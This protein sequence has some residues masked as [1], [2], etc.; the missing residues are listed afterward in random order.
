MDH[1][2]TTTT[3]AAAPTTTSLALVGCGSQKPDPDAFPLPAKDA[4]TS[5]YFGLKYYL[6]AEAYDHHAIISA[7]YG[8]L[9]PEEEIEWYDE[10]LSTKAEAREW[11]AETA[12]AI[13]E[14]IAA[15]D[16]DRV[17]IFAGAKYRL[18]ADHLPEDIEVVNPFAPMD[19][20][21]GQQRQLSAWQDLLEGQ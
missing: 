12:P 5:G 4:Y 20:I 10:T 3:D 8:L 18:V 6:A 16:V 11:A 14:F 19:G 1:A 17:T 21:H 9:Q 13:C 2:T 7:K 15:H